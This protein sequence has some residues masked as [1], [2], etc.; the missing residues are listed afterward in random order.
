MLNK[1]KDSGL[2]LGG[3]SPTAPPLDSPLPSTSEVGEGVLHEKTPQGLTFFRWVRVSQSRGSQA[4][5]LLSSLP[6]SMPYA[7]LLITSIPRR[8]ARELSMRSCRRSVCF[9]LLMDS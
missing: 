7:L 8:Q 3:C 1:I 2:T 9:L 6:S 5:L 4:S